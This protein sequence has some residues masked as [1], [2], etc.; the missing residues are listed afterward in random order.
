MKLITLFQIIFLIKSIKSIDLM[1]GLSIEPF[2][3]SLKENGLFEIIQSIKNVY[4]QDVAIIS[5]E[6]LNKNHNGN[7]KKL[8]TEYMSSKPPVIIH[9]PMPHI[10]SIPHISSKPRIPSESAYPK[11]SIKPSQNFSFIKYVLKKKFSSAKSNL[12]YNRIIDRAKKINS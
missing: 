9:P 1:K 11:P 5:C 7:C 8:V 3:D 2:K 10:T 12:I 6:E 4:G